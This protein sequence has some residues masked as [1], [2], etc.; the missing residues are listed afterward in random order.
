MFADTGT[1]IIVTHVHNPKLAIVFTPRDP[2][3]VELY[4]GFITVQILSDYRIIRLNDLVD[5][6]FNHVKL[7]GGQSPLKMIIAFRFFAVDM[8]RKTPTTVME[9]NHGLI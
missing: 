2:V 9:A 4:S 1:G 8:G 7:F 3:Q 5:F 6:G